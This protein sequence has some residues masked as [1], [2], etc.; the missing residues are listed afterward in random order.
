MTNTYEQNMCK[1][2]FYPKS[3]T[4]FVHMCW[5]F[6]QKQ[7]LVKIVQKW[8]IFTKQSPKND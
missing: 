5:S 4:T 2:Q 3:G 6:D 7:V 1:D 8:A